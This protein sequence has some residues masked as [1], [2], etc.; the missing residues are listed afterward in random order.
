MTLSSLPYTIPPPPASLMESRSSTTF[1]FSSS[2]NP[3]P[4]AP[5]G[6]AHHHRRPRPATLH[7]L[8]VQQLG[9]HGAGAQAAARTPSGFIPLPS[10]SA[11]PLFPAIFGG[12]PPT[13]DLTP[14]ARSP[15]SSSSGSSTATAGHAAPS[16]LVFA[17][18]HVRAESQP[19]LSLTEL[20]EMPTPSA[21]S[22]KADVD[23]PLQHQPRPVTP[24]ERGHASVRDHPTKW[25][26]D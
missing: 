13:G 24:A 9:R 7:M 26:L 20:F 11:A 21:A 19:G 22:A 2:R 4:D 1:V 16:T 5:A 10:P 17:A 8:S 12:A 6:L 15:A 3:H 18:T 23:E 25:A 14:R